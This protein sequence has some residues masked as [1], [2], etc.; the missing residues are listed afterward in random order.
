MNAPDEAAQN[1]SVQFLAQ[2]ESVAHGGTES[3]KEKLSALYVACRSGNLVTVTSLVEKDRVDL[4]EA[5]DQGLTP[6]GIA[7][8]EGHLPVIQYLDDKNA[9]FSIRS[10]KGDH[11]L[12][13]IKENVDRTI[14]DVIVKLC[15]RE[16]NSEL[17]KLDLFYHLIVS[18]SFFTATNLLHCE[19]V[20]IRLT[21]EFGETL[22]HRL[23]GT[24][25]EFIQK[26][27]YPFADFGRAQIF[28]QMILL[29]ID[30]L[31]CNV[32][33]YTFFHYLAFRNGL[34]LLEQLY[35]FLEFDI[36]MQS[37]C[38]ATLLYL[39][40]INGETETALWLIKNNAN[41]NLAPKKPI[42]LNN[43]MREFIHSGGNIWTPLI[44]AF[45]VKGHV[46]EVVS[47]LVIKGAKIFGSNSAHHEE[48]L[49]VFLESFLETVAD[50][51]NAISLLEK[52]IA[53][54]SDEEIDLFLFKASPKAAFCLRQIFKEDERSHWGVRDDR[55]SYGNDESEQLRPI[56]IQSAFP[57][58]RQGILRQHELQKFEIS[59]ATFKLVHAKIEELKLKALKQQEQE[60]Q[61]KYI[62]DLEKENQ[63]LRELKGTYQE[64]VKTDPVVVETLLR[65]QTRQP[66]TKV[67]LPTIN[68]HLTV[69]QT[70]EILIANFDNLAKDKT[71]V[72]VRSLPRFL[73]EFVDFFSHPS[74]KLH[75]MLGFLDCLSS[76][77][78]FIHK[79]IGINLPDFGLEHNFTQAIW[80]FFIFDRPFKGTDTN[81]SYTDGAES[82]FMAM[83]Q[84]DKKFSTLVNHN[85]FCWL[86]LER[87][88]DYFEKQNSNRSFF[89]SSKGSKDD[90]DFNKRCVC[91]R[92]LLSN[93]A[94]PT[95]RFFVLAGFIFEERRMVKENDMRF[96]L[97]SK[98][99]FTLKNK[100]EGLTLDSCDVAY[101]E[102]VAT[103]AQAGPAI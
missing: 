10:K 54:P 24:E 26:S 21:N 27:S 86:I 87:L 60:Q 9:T 4:N 13:L 5:D 1:A 76:P 75:V 93:F 62:Q 55:L 81:R 67:E 74:I 18:G 58:V 70:Y 12:R 31:Q 103:V 59:L 61:M 14:L 53:N 50:F 30:P 16:D 42:S 48:L 40:C 2:E 92:N 88:R 72:L 6:L 64:N 94:S 85:V 8:I 65:I 96:P 41:L 101:R 33:G 51:S 100:I 7:C 43:E 68:S 49:Q 82:T 34:D 69:K 78:N 91:V 98:L 17:A 83:Y 71:N 63:A 25:K 44:A 29:G 35:K 32:Q 45:R 102:A 36:N 38:G 52:V 73:R 89:L 56:K 99:A 80:H 11:I 77:Q 22:L 57:A 39:A 23:A 79:L 95:N 3:I 15:L 37:E 19:S 46:N 90:I 28:L 47:T 84:C 66:I 20:N 97:L